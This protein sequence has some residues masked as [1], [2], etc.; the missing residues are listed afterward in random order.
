[1]KSKTR[2]AADKAGLGPLVRLSDMQPGVI[3]RNTLSGN[4]Y[5]VI[6]NYGRWAVAVRECTIMN[7]CEWDIVKKWNRRPNA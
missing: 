6:G 1:M 4:V 2:K 5:V 7:P 3:V